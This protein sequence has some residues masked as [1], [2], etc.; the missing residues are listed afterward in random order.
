MTNV[1]Q[2][3]KQKKQGIVVST[4]HSGSDSSRPQPRGPGPGEAT[5]GGASVTG[6]TWGP[7]ERGSL[8]LPLH[9]IQHNPQNVDDDATWS[10]LKTFKTKQ[11]SIGKKKNAPIS[12][13]VNGRAPFLSL[14]SLGG[15]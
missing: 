7:K 1:K 4:K 6:S 8:P 2:K 5:G 12:A 10:T 14:S 13:C 11:S 3:Q 15:A 9:P